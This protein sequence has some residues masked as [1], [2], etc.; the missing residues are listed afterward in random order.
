MRLCVFVCGS[1]WK[2]SAMRF[3]MPFMRMDR[4][5]FPNILVVQP[6]VMSSHVLEVTLNFFLLSLFFSFS[7]SFFVMGKVQLQNK[8]KRNKRYCLLIAGG[9]G[10]K[11][12]LRVFF[13]TVSYCGR[14][15]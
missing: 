7:F 13:S 8:E 5:P 11:V 4:R 14:R 10:K 12:E 15:G 6:P 9:G 3:S 2:C 1:V